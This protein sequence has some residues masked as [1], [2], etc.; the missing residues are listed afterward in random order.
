MSATLLLGAG[1]AAMSVPVLWW[2][3]SGDRTAVAGSR[4]RAGVGATVDMR[5]AVLRHGASERAVQPLVERLARRARRLTPQGRLEAL[6]R[7][8]LLAGAPAA[9]P[10]ERVLA[11]KL[12]LG[13][14]G[15]VFGLFR[16]LAGFSPA[17]I[18][19]LTSASALGY[20]GP[21]LALRNRAEKRQKQIGLEL[22]DT[23]DQI[24][25]SVEAGLGFEAAM[26]RAGRS[27]K[28]PLAQELQ[29]TLQDTQAGMS[30]LQALKR[31]VDR[32]DVAELRHFVLA[33]LQADSYG[34]PIAQVLRVQ[35][36]ELR[37]KRRQR[38]EER[39]MKL[40]VK[41]IFPLIL[42]ILPAMFIVIIG[43]AVI[44]IAG[45]FSGFGALR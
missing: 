41:V 32:T 4:L 19:V 35:S 7:R 17:S 37:V 9:W 18:L 39:A 12:L 3:V 13:G 22:P 30:R 1:A 24:T 11:G 23:L 45:A 33:L 36:S 14:A 6:E 29:R 20:F 34:V 26:A 10:M 16:C 21:D 15:F 28:G 40:P 42:C 5:Q 27:G 38:A 25:I 2:A 44:R 31:L 43:P 8:V